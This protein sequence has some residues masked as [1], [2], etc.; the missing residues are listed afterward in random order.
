M[1]ATLRKTTPRVLVAA[2]AALTACVPA[3][4]DLFASDTAIVGTDGDSTTSTGTAAATAT[5]GDTTTTAGTAE[6]LTTTTM[7]SGDEP[8]AC[9][10]PIT[11]CKWDQDRDGV[12]DN[13]DNAP[14][15]PNPDQ[16]DFDGDGF[17]DVADLCPTVPSAD[18]VADSDKDGLGNDCDLC[19][20]SAAHYN[21]ALDLPAYL[22]VRNIPGVDDSDHDGIGDACDNCVRTPN[23]QGY[24]D[25]LDPFEIGDPLR[26]PSAS[27]TPASTAT[28]ASSSAPTA[29]PS[30]PTATSSR[31]RRS[32]WRRPASAPCRRAAR[33]RPSRSP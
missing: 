27:T 11:N 22:K 14:R 17:G 26:A 9:G 21:G 13:C 10:A 20:R 25:G 31:C 15:L 33:R 2:L 3:K 28:A 6:D 4:L 19:K 1:T 12:A 7:D 16:A 5:E 18:N 32:C 29:P 8:P 23:C 30:T 24:G